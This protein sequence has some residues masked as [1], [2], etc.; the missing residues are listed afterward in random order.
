MD[1]QESKLF[2]MLDSDM[3]GERANAL[4]LLRELLKKG[5]RSFRAIVQEFE[6]L[7]AS[8]EQYIAANAS[9]AQ[10]Y[11]EAQADIARK[12]AEIA[13]LRAAARQQARRN[14]A[15]NMLGSGRPWWRSR[16]AQVIAAVAALAYIG[17]ETPLVSNGWWWLFGNDEF[18]K[19]ATRAVWGEG[20]SVPRVLSVNNAEYWVVLE[21]SV[22]KTSYKTSDGRLTE[23]R[24]LHLYT[25]RAEPGPYGDYV[26]P[27]NLRS[28][29][30]KALNWSER[31]VVC[32]RPA[33]WETATRPS[34][35]PK[36]FDWRKA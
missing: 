7:K 26:T 9:A 5:N 25:V 31:A 4:E 28:G 11:T 2:A 12:D 6:Q 10:Q 30:T 27:E 19:A 35:A 14:A 33:E 29:W 16:P 8:L 15:A 17:F 21:G 3:P 23:F 36:T 13:Q 20:T 1:A 32:K 22:D 18:S 34:L 24:C